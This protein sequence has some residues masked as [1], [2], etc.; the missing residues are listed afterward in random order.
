MKEGNLLIRQEVD[1]SLGEWR[2]EEK[3]A[4]ELQQITGEL[5]FNRSIELILFGQ[6]IH[7]SKTS[8]ILN[9]HRLAQQI[10][11]K[12]YTV[13]TSL[14]VAQAI[15]RVE[16]LAPCKID[17]GRLGIEWLEEKYDYNNPDEF[18][19]FKL[20]SFISVDP[21]NQK[22]R[23]VVLYGFG[24]IGRLAARELVNQTG[25]GEQLR[26]KAIVVRPK[27]KDPYE[28]A[29]KR[30]A[31]LAHDSVHGSFPGFI[32]VKDNG[33]EIV[34][35]GNKI[36]MIYANSPAE[37]DYTEY[38]IHNALLIDNTGVWRARK[39]L[40]NHL[41][42]GIDKVLLT[43]P[44]KGDVPN[45]VYKAKEQN[46]NIDEHDVFSAASCTNNAIVPVV[47]ILETEFGIEK[48]HIETIH[49]FTNDQ[50]LID[51]FHKKPRRGKSAPINMVITSTGA[52]NAVAKV[53]PK[54]KGKLTGNAIRVPTPNV[55]LAILNL[56]LNHATNMVELNA[57][58]KEASLSGRYK[59]Q[60][61]YSTSTEYVSSDAIGA[62]ST[63]VLDAPS[64]IVSEDGKNVTI[65]LWYDN[66][67]GYTCQVVRLAKHLAK[68]R[69]YIY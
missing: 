42:P 24:R 23:D 9:A 32:D 6:R 4:L 66:E 50:N 48:G 40:E 13:E 30:A 58:L 8:E 18:V 61:L 11:P 25:K 10:S 34:I 1:H 56:S 63:S 67:Y 27:L 45:I 39:G 68:V 46:F 51:N 14:V 52:A 65:Y 5:R 49:S 54:L 29:S 12:K 33:K 69:R 19:H 7:N 22:A 3:L 28:E 47:D 60:L 21:K 17:I 53:F 57:L 35:N 43:A 64:T 31:L 55:S 38:G 44:G 26:L 59:E 20:K 41:R 2:N 62:N 37:I 36:Q 16:K 15:F